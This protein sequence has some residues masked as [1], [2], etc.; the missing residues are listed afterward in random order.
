MY[1]GIRETPS[2]Y[3]VS[4]RTYG[5]LRGRS[6]FQRLAV[7]SSTRGETNSDGRP[8]AKVYWRYSHPTVVSNPGHLKKWICDYELLPSA[9]FSFHEHVPPP[10]VQ[11]EIL[12]SWDQRATRAKCMPFRR[13]TTRTATDK[14]P[15]YFGYT[16]SFSVDMNDITE[17]GFFYVP[18][19]DITDSTTWD[20]ISEGMKHKRGSISF[21]A[22][23]GQTVEEAAEGPSGSGRRSSMPTLAQEGVSII[24][25]GQSEKNMLPV[26]Q[27]DLPPHGETD[28]GTG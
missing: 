7:T 20:K 22:S 19:R 18:V 8:L 23:A 24:E 9:T 17:D 25:G 5:I 11:I 4:N 26:L 28:R 27:Q 2:R 16:V 21:G 10:W 13:S 3:V 12:V 1:L 15:P 6:I 14:V